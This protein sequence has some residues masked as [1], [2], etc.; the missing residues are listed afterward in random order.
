[1]CHAHQ[2]L[3]AM[4]CKPGVASQALQAN[5]CKL[6]FASRAMPVDGMPAK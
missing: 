6:S 4:L 5:L 2:A 1:M 3:H